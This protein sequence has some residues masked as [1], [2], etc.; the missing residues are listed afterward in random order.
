MGGQ[1]QERLGRWG[2]RREREL[3]ALAE[4]QHGV[5]SLRQLIALGFGRRAIERRLDSWRLRQ[6]HRGVYAVGH[7]G[8]SQHGRWLAAVL[9]YG[10][11]AVLSHRSAAS[12]WNLRRPRGA[13]VDVTSPRGRAGRPGIAFHECKLDP[14]DLTIVDSIPVTGVARTLFDLSEVVNLSQLERACE[15]ADRLGLIE[16]KILERVVERGW[17]RHA[18]R[19]MRRIR[20]DARAPT[21]TRSPLED[22]FVSFCREHRVPSPAFNTTVLGFEVD[23]LWPRQRVV[24]ELDG[25]AFH[26]HRAAFE[27]DRARDT[28]L[29]AAGYRVI[30]LTHRR[31]ERDAT[32]VARELRHLLDVPELDHP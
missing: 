21:T 5:V 29:Q 30:R 25:F 6:L 7:S 16:T 15:E 28:A 18:L 20:T 23:A 2:I 13:L 14:E 9:A 4:R 1:P 31:L 3:A 17:G 26:H 27:R 8:L 22:R 32:T 24:V 10:A 19:P 11:E 12:I